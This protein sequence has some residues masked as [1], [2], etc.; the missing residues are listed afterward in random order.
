MFSSISLVATRP[1]VGIIKTIP[2]VRAMADPQPN[3]TAVTMVVSIW[4]FLLDGSFLGASSAAKIHDA[5][6][7]GAT[8]RRGAVADR[9]EPLQARTMA[10]ATHLSR[11]AGGHAHWRHATRA[12]ECAILD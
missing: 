3:C 9:A 10:F 2:K 8:L 7:C 1:R 5:M 11:S 4:S 12:G 6:T